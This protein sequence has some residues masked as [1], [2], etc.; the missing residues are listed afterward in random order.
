MKAAIANKREAIRR[1]KNTATSTISAKRAQ[2]KWWDHVSYGLT[3][4]FTSLFAL[5]YRTDFETLIEFVKDFRLRYNEQM[6]EVK[7]WDSQRILDKVS[8]S[9]TH[10]LH[11]PCITFYELMC[12]CDRIVSSVG[13]IISIFLEARMLSW[14]LY[15]VRV[16]DVWGDFA[17]CSLNSRSSFVRSFFLRTLLKNSHIETFLEDGRSFWDESQFPVRSSISLN[18][19]RQFALRPTHFWSP[20]I[21]M[22]SYRK[23]AGNTNNKQQTSTR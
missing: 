2:K 22:C 23:T 18:F 14:L 21:F 4:Y 19:H 8:N 9:R 17:K 20:P 10:S 5:T 1:R 15:A 6:D 3:N 16:V 13:G 11:N 12:R 7:T